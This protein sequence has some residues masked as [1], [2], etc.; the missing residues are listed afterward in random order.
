MAAFCSGC[1]CLWS[2]PGPLFLVAEKAVSSSPPIGLHLM[3]MLALLERFGCKVF[4][5]VEQE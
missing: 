1:K 5:K 2:K 4:L 3:R